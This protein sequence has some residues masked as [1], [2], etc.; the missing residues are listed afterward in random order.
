M[1]FDT[2][3]G[4]SGLGGYI[5]RVRGTDTQ[6]VRNSVINGDE[7]A[8]TKADYVDFEAAKTAGASVA[9]TQTIDCGGL[10][11]AGEDAGLLTVTYSASVVI[12]NVTSA[13]SIE[14]VLFSIMSTLDFYYEVP[15]TILPVNLA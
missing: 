4:G 10:A 1:A 3:M 5:T 14:L 15:R 2:N 13:I 6:F 12:D 9:G 7:T 8:L 11:V